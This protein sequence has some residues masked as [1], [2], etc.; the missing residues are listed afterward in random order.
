MLNLFDEK[1]ENSQNLSGDELLTE[2]A[3]PVAVVAVL[4]LLLTS[5]PG[6]TGAE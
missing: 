1:I 5:C 4:A 3:A 2:G 6:N